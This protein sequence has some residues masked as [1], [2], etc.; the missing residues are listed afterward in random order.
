[1]KNSR[2]SVIVAIRVILISLNCFALIWLYQY[3]SRP[4]TTLFTAIILVFQTVNLIYYHNRV[5]RDLAN[6]LIFL[7]ENDT[8]LAFSKQR[9]E[10]SFKG[11]SFHLDKIN[12]KLQTARL[13]KE[14]Q[15]Q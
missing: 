10:R 2:Y 12:Q 11:L 14:R 3:T 5:Q 7:H 1:M 4:A 8:T 6:F 9:I 15:Y 13:E